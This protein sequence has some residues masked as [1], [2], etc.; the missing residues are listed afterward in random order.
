MTH[1]ITGG[2][3]SD[4]SCIPVCP[5]Q[6]I[7]PRPGDPDFTTAEQLYI[8]PAICIDCMACMDECPVNAITPDWELPS[9]LGPFLSINSDYFALNPIEESAPPSPVRKKLSPEH[10]ELAVAIV[11]SGPAGCYAAAELSQIAGVRV[12]LFDRLP[13][14]FGLV[15]AGVAPDHAATK[16]IVD[17]FGVTLKRP[18]VDC[19]FNVDVGRDISVDELLQYH[20]AVIWAGGATDDRRLGIPGE[21]LIGCES[22]RQFVGWYNGHPDHADKEVDLSSENVVVIGNGN[23]ALDVARILTQPPTELDE[24][25]IAEH[26]IEQLR[27]SAVSRVSITARR[28]PQFAAFTVG[29]LIGLERTAD[30]VILAVKDEVDEAS[31]TCSHSEELLAA[32][33]LRTAPDAGKSVSFRFGLTPQR[34]LGTD[35]VEGVEFVRNDGEV[36]VIDASLVIRAIG[37]QGVPVDGLPFDPVTHTLPHESGRVMDPATGSSLTGIYCSGWIK[38]GA[39]GVIGTNRTDA[40][41]TVDAMLFDH[42]RGRLDSPEAGVD[43]CARLVRERQPDVVDRAAWD[44]IDKAERAAGKSAGRTRLK[45]VTIPTMLAASNTAD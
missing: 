9:D 18:N 39:T 36:E 34:I 32:A 42:S 17:Q 22:A 16:K 6:C 21:D 38:R 1:V 4:A 10:P 44:R 13:T 31:D 30:V 29:E 12:S 35:R 25:D 28:G 3:C 15:R 7:R 40:A 11:G 8:D 20:H 45:L 2:C 27:G 23:V 14:P 43:E 33:A 5:V 41:E 37:Y 19:F 26:A 24:T